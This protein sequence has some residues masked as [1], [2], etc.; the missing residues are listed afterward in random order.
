M[1][2]HKILTFW[3]YFFK[4]KRAN[5]RKKIDSCK[6]FEQKKKYIAI[7]IGFSCV[8]PFFFVPLRVFV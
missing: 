6:F 5:V 7:K 4:K 3:L 1:F 2:L 8:C